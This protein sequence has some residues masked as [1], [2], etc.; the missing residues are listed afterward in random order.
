ME[1]VRRP[2]PSR[3]RI[4]REHKSGSARVTIDG[5]DMSHHVSAVTW[6]MEAGR[7]PTATITLFDVEIDA[8]AEEGAPASSN[9]ETVPTRRGYVVSRPSLPVGRVMVAT[10][11]G[12]LFIDA[13][14]YD[15]LDDD[16]FSQFMGAWCSG[17]YA[18][19][20]VALGL[21]DPRDGLKHLAEANEAERARMEN[22]T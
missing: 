2:K 10:D 22:G 20:Q 14:L 9:I 8:E 5:E 17:D 11:K 21:P 6:S 19:T 13:D 3:V 7:L 1:N 12:P 16:A 18:A 4:E 15:R